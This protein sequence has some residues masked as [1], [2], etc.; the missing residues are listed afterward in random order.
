M[1][2]SAEAGDRPRRWSGWDTLALLLD[3]AVVSIG[4]LWHDP[5]ADEAQAWL[6]ARS[7]GFWQIVA[8]GVRYEGSPALW[9]CFLHLLILLH[10]SY[11][12]M[13]WATGAMALA[14]IA[15]FL[16]WSPFPPILR[17][18]LPLTFWLAYQDAVIARSYVLFTPLGFAAAALLRNRAQRPI[19]LAVIL[20]LCANISLHGF[21]A[22]LGLA[23]VA[24]MQAW[25]SRSRSGVAGLG[26]NPAGIAAALILLTGVSVAV[27][28]AYPP[29]DDSWPAATNIVK[30]ATIMDAQLLGRPLAAK[31][32]PHSSATTAADQL[33]PLPY[34]RHHRTP[35]QSLHKRAARILGTITFPLSDAGLYGLLL[36][37]ALCWLAIRTPPTLEAG[38]MG[39]PGLLPYLVLVLIFSSMYLEPRHCGMMMMGF[40]IALW[41]VWPSTTQPLTRGHRIVTALLVLM[42]VEQIAWTAHALWRST[43]TASAPSTATAAFLKQYSG[44]PVDGFYYHSINVLPYFRRNIYANQSSPYWLWSKHQ[45]IDRDAPIAIAKRPRIIVVGGFRWSPR[46]SAVSYDWKRPGA[47]LNSIWQNDRYRIVAYAKQH[48]YSET[49]DFCGYQFMRFGYV[50]RDCDII[51]EPSAEAR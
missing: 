50:E 38:P 32:Q 30:S 46:D 26:R 23:A 45:H 31:Y 4:L 3:A 42:A 51:L 37:G 25:R 36:F 21:L 28:S 10:V 18:L 15:I 41:L 43:R 20:A 29:P 49:H 27:F 11:S 6:I 12:G 9:H 7:M 2:R 40:F 17:L 14:G 35:L 13:A 22:A 33:V 24:L 8:H 47:G 16:R 19:L 34:P 48:G 1:E 44:V 5:W 39:W